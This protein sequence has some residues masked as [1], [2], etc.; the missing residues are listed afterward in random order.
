M[1]HETAHTRGVEWVEDM[2]REKE[3]QLR[4]YILWIVGSLLSAISAIVGTSF[5]YISPTV[6]KVIVHITCQPVQSSEY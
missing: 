4:L 2:H 6:T 3:K 5:D 1:T